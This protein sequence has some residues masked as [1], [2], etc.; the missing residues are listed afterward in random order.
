MSAAA[1]GVGMA[2][3]GTFD[4]TFGGMFDALRHTTHSEWES[5]QPADNE[6]PDDS[7]EVTGVSA[8]LK[9]G[10]VTGSM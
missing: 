2:R 9:P 10:G 4:G 3:D 7:G 1:A 5:L 6:P 8:V